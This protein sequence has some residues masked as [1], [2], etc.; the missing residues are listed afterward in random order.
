MFKMNN[1][2]NTFVKKCTTPINI[3][4]QGLIRPV[5]REYKTGQG[6]S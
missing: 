3:Y 5:E 6:T 1:Y 4:V 2:K